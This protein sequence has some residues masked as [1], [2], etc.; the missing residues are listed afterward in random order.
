MSSSSA[1]AVL[2]RIYELPW[3]TGIEQEQRVPQ[4]RADGAR[5]PSC[6]SRCCSRCCR[7]R[8]PIRRWSR[9]CRSGSRAWFSS[10]RRRRLRRRSF[11]RSQSPS[12]SRSP[13]SS[14]ARFAKSRRRSRNRNPSRRPSTRRSS[15]ASA[16]PSRGSCRSRSSSRRCA[17]RRTAQ[18]LDRTQVVGGR[19][20]HDAARRAFV[21]HVA[22]RHEQR[23][24]Q[25]C[26]PEPQHGRRRLG[27]SRA[28]QVENPVD[29]FELA[30]GAAQRSG[31]SDKASRSREEIERVFDAEQ[32]P[33]FTL[34]NRALRQNPALEGKVVLASDDRRRR[35]GDVLR[36]RVFGAQR[37]RSRAEARAARAAVP[38]RA[39]TTSSRSRPRNRSTSSRPKLRALV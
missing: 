15:R 26:R 36:G 32:R 13:S 29:S 22:R 14:S 6:C 4:D 3:S 30:G 10:A 11:A 9:N 24:H 21:D 33:I 16:R 37:S 31:T 27:R 2:Y 20:G 5:A 8:R 23:W 25:H 35:Q 7:R 12:P 18:R 19:R 17:T 28:T 1:G 38:V 34:Y 39:A